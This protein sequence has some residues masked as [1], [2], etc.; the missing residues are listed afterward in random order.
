MYS[1]LF[2]STTSPSTTNTNTHILSLFEE[3]KKPHILRKTDFLPARPL[4]EN[5]FMKM[6]NK[7]YKDSDQNRRINIM[8]KEYM[9]WYMKI[10]NMK[11]N[12]IILIPIET[13]YITKYKV[14]LQNYD[15]TVMT[16]NIDNIEFK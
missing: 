6:R 9:E 7:I 4:N 12:K 3:I 5:D 13:G 2:G 8:A 1:F 14:L 16:Y 15:K 10:N 11:I